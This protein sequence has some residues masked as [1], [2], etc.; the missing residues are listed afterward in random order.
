MA[1]A[2]EP[3]GVTAFQPAFRRPAGE[4]DWLAAF[5]EAGARRFGETGLPT[6]R[7]EAWKYTSLRPLA[8]AKYQPVPANDSAGADIAA[9]APL[10]EGAAQAV[11]VDG[12][13]AP[14]LSDLDG[15]DG[16][17]RRW[18]EAAGEDWLA[19]TLNWPGGEALQAMYALNAAAFDDGLA[20]RVG[21]G[22]P[23][24]RPLEVVFLASACDGPRMWHPRLAIDVGEGGAAT[25]LE[26]HIGPDKTAYLA[27]HGAD[28]RV[29]A[30]A[31]LVHAKLQGEGADGRHLAM[32]RVRLGASALYDGFILTTGAGLSRS[33]VAA[34]LEGDDCEIRLNGA[35]SIG[36][37]QHADHTSRIDH[38]G[39]GARSRQVFAGAI[40]GNA[41]GVFQGHI[42]VDRLA[43]RTDGHQL[44]RALLLSD[45]AE[46]DAKPILE[47]YADD[48]KCSHG[49]T[50]GD[51][52]ADQLFYLR[53]RGVPAEQA[54][55][56]VVRGFLADA[57][58]GLSDAAAKAAVL[59]E[60]DRALD[61]ET[62]L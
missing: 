39:E 22:A 26:R 31:R 5:R 46:I 37:R 10:I 44:N 58:A 30:G 50:A 15:L 28:V 47:I 27:N 35:Y 4:P 43:Q 61:L 56:L 32:T 24:A 48:V 52:D 59:A 41:R 11:F 25:V 1:R 17:V 36:G 16:S 18:G 8:R 23:L 42:V 62:E 14:G 49:A 60:L 33:E 34:R 53:A 55:R 3:I 6:N 12:R 2:S 19:E 20:I 57:A 13:Y 54:R 45:H 29:A 7:E 21:A 40:D 9:P 51:I 38:L